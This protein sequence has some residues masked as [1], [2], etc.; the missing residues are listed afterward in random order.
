[1]VE[2][3][4]ISVGCGNMVLLHLSDGT[5]ML[6]DCNVTNENAVQ[7]LGYLARVMG[8]KRV[9]DIFVNSHRDSDHMRG[10]RRVHAYFPIRLVWDSGVVGTSPY[11]P[12]YQEY[13]QLRREVGFREVQA[14]TYWSYQDTIVRVMNSRAP[15]YTDSN[16]Q[17]LVLKV[18]YLGSSLL[19][20]GDTDY[21]PWKEKILP[22]YRSR[23]KS[24]ILHAAHHGSPSFFDDPSDE[25]YYYT[26]H[27]KAIEPDIT[28]VSVGSNVHGLPDP[29]AME[30][31]ERHSRGSKQG[32]KVF[33]TDRQ[34][35]IKL[36]LKG[37]GEWTLFPNE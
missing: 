27:I 31:Y 8:N 12:E 14:R 6:Y 25:K 21:R 15:D 35:N 5:T 11:S 24:S 7:V 9:I 2:V 34:G 28:I 30:L 26:K 10:I 4:F 3:H 18:E 22:F 29:N 23:V 17:S 19:V 36:L 16:S 37:S 32:H 13:M 33:R 1:M 20:A